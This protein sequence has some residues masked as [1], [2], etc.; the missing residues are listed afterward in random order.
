MAVEE[1]MAVVV[2]GVE[3]TEAGPVPAP[4]KERYSA[5]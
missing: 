2:V 3:V 1:A 5:P 4:E